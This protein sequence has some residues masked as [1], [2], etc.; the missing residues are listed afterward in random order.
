M[1]LIDVVA[2]LIGVWAA[3]AIRLGEWWPAWLDGVLWLF[4]LAVLT[5]IP[6]LLGFGLYHSIVRHAGGSLAYVIVKGV[7][8]GALLMIAIWLLAGG[9]LVPRSAWIIYWLV[10]IALI[11]SSRFVIRDLL[12]IRIRR[13]APRERVAIYGAGEAGVQLANALNHSQELEPAVFLDDDPDLEG[14]RIAGLSVRPP[15]KLTRLIERDQISTVLLAMPSVPHRR[16]REIIDALAD[17]P[18]RVMAMPAL[19]EI[20]AGTKRV[21]DVR[22]VD[23][24][25]LLGRDPVQPNRL[26]LERCITGQSVLV[27]GA[28]G[29]IGA[30]LCRQIAGL[31]PSRLLLLDRSEPALYAIEQEVG[32]L[33]A[34]KPT[35]VIALLGSVTNADRMRRVMT[36]FQ[37]ETVYHAAAYK[38]VPIV[39]HNPIEGVQ[40]NIVGTLRT[41]E[42][43]TA[44]GVSTFVLISTDKAVRPTNVMGATKRFAELILQGLA[45]QNPST[46]FCMV[47]FGNVLDSSGSVVPLFR[48]QIRH[49][50]PVTVTHPEVIRYFMTIPEAAQLVLQAGSMG[51]GGDVFVLEMG[52]PV[53]I[54]DLARQMIRLS[55]LEVQDEDN[56]EG[57]IRI[58]FKGLRPGEKLYEELLIGERDEPT[59]HPRIRRARE[60]C[61]PWPAVESFLE[62]LEG[63][64]GRCDAAELR[65]VLK[66]AVHGYE[67]ET[68][69]V[70]PLWAARQR[71]ATGA[72]PADSA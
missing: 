14:S 45:Q 5:T 51:V 64:C 69:I 38:H 18:V 52:E 67:P 50:G 1:V 61:L 66:E 12:R 44:S 53:R 35:E 4:P 58:E 2:V 62:R 63:A 68:E 59:E 16:R 57:D 24:E 37:V 72:T 3:F 56:P 7:S 32:R 46:R 60:E 40:N 23:I 26:L 30:E 11:G 36:G 13:L 47:R 8:V 25:D 10:A 27:T 39:E 41:A 33:C 48:D 54:L 28:G 31:A 20:A 42:A 43:A 65:A 17:L 22:E 70:D 21:D 49:G 55:G 6:A 15:G 29:S 9:P 34:G 19:A 71:A